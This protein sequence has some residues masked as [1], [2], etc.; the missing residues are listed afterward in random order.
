MMKKS[1]KKDR[2]QMAARISSYQTVQ[3]K[4][5]HIAAFVLDRK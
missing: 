2:Q 3:V 5:P 1:N 4:L